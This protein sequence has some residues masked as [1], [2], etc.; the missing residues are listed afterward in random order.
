MTTN[1]KKPSNKKSIIKELYND[2]VES[3]ELKAPYVP[4]QEEYIEGLERFIS[5]VP[6][7]KKERKGIINRSIGIKLDGIEYPSINSGLRS[8]G[9]ELENDER[10]SK[11][12][13]INKNLKKSGSFEFES[14]KF[15]LI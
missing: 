6:Q 8:I 4:S 10:R 1:V 12:M 9:Y 13:K 15:E 14:H 2:V 5:Y 11:W 3:V 7:L